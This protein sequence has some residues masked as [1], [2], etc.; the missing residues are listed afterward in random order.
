[1]IFFAVTGV[2]RSPV[3][4]NGTITTSESE[5]LADTLSSERLPLRDEIAT[6][7]ANANGVI[8]RA[9]RRVISRFSRSIAEFMVGGRGLEPLTF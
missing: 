2:N 3:S 8:K 6:K 1:M 7:P 9:R 4:R 5:P